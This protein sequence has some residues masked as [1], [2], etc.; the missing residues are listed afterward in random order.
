MKTPARPITIQSTK[1]SRV[2][3]TGAADRC[4]ARRPPWIGPA[5]RK[6]VHRNQH[7]QGF[8]GFMNAFLV[9]GDDRYL[10]VWRK[11]IDAVNAN[12]KTVDGKT[13]YPHMYGEQGWY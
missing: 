1:S 11:Q 6:T 5:T 13:V 10:D 3:S 4:C 8:I 7:F 9:T 2:C 12:Q